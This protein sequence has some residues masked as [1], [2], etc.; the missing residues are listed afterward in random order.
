MKLIHRVAF[1][2]IAGLAPIIAE[3]IYNANSLETTRE[4]EIRQTALHQAEY[5]ASDLDRI[6]EGVHG[7]MLA[8]ADAP[9]IRELNP[10]LCGPFVAKLLHKL[11]YLYALSVVDA[12]GQVKCAASPDQLSLNIKD[13]SY[14]QR[15]LQSPDFVI[16]EYVVGYA[17]S[18]PAL[19]LAL[20]ILADDG[21]HLGTV[22]TTL[23]L[24]WLS[25]QL[26]KRGVPDGGS[27]TVADRN[28]VILARQPLPE[29]FVGTKIPDDYIKLL[30]EPSSGIID[31][32]SQDGTARV[33]G[34]IPVGQSPRGLY[35]SAG[36]SEQSSI[37]LLHAAAW[38]QFFVTMI[39]VL[40]SVLGAYLLSGYFVARPLAQLLKTVQKWQSG[41]LQ[42]RT[43]LTSADGEAGLLGQE[44]DRT[45]DQLERR[46]NTIGVLLREMAH[47]SKNKISLLISLASQ[48]VKGRSSVEEYKRAIIDRLM[49]MSKAQDL[50]LDAG[51][52]IVLI[53]D[54]VKAHTEAF[55]T[56]TNRV[57][58]TGP[59]QAL[60]PEHA[61]HLGMAIHELATNAVKYGALSNGKG[62]V[63]VT[64]QLIKDSKVEIE[65]VWSERGGPRVKVPQRA[66][67]GRTLIEKIVPHQL[68]GRSELQYK[69]AGVIWT[70][71]FP[72]VQL[73]KDISKQQK[74][75]QSTPETPPNVSLAGT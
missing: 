31:V 43:G 25:A 27:V 32:V 13:R 44:F 11:K 65:F 6:I 49:A 33:L 30:S 69:P 48:L 10:Q 67:F 70:M 12:T 58:L 26:L 71:C 34:Y 38:R 63:D 51:D 39:S 57:K 41:D 15:S 14:F 62:T 50:L 20:P 7:V 40:I 8:L 68:G 4:A 73:E 74:S 35:V 66:G 46:Q 64:W 9:S 55:I 17:S 54:V 59:A 5:A 52:R 61:R 28:G 47:R 45:V 72:I 21:H 37:G 2:V 42:A 16:G 3:E 36:L 56:E 18:Q 75:N 19:P 1:I 29:K 22:V 53:S 60:S 23:N 24:E